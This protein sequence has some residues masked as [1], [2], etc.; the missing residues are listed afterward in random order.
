MEAT[1][2]SRTMVGAPA[3]RPPRRTASADLMRHAISMLA[4]LEQARYEA[5]QRGVPAAVTK[6]MVDRTARE[7]AKVP[8]EVRP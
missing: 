1:E 6:A 3:P 4:L 7:I 8:R 2:V 5:Q